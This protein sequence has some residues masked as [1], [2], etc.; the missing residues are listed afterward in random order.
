[1]CTI[2]CHVGGG[3][4]VEKR[5]KVYKIGMGVEEA[6]IVTKFHYSETVG[7]LLLLLF[8]VYDDGTGGGLL[9]GGGN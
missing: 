8:D 3:E 4:Q 6:Q 1:M 5:E 2:Q 7:R 9:L